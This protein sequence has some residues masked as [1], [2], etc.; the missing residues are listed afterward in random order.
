MSRKIPYEEIMDGIKGDVDYVAKEAYQKGLDDA[1]ECAR[2]INCIPSDGGI[3]GIELDD[4]FYTDSNCVIMKNFSAS[5]AM[6][7][8]KA[9]EEDKNKVRVGDEVRA[10]YGNAVVT[11]VNET[12][13]TAKF[14]YKTGENGCDY[15]RVIE[16]TGRHFDEIEKLLEKMRGEE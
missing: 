8:I 9:Y 7:R 6:A 15:L 10:T 1:W 11:C 16:R 12:E 3:S 4:I 5:E 14:F 2:K 13:K